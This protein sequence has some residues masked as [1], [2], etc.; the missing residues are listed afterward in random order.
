[1]DPSKLTGLGKVGGVPGIA[2]GMVVLVVCAALTYTGLLPEAW[3]GPVLVLAIA[4]AVLLGFVA[5]ARV[6]VART[7]GK[8]SG[9]TQKNALV[10]KAETKGDNAPVVQE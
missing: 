7:E 2:L 8:G 1:M 9:V 4:G 6:R 3:R 10:A 5:L